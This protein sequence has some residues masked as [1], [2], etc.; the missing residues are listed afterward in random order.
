[1]KKLLFFGVVGIIMLLLSGCGSSQPRVDEL[2]LSDAVVDAPELGVVEPAVVSPVVEPSRVNVQ[3]ETGRTPPAEPERT[4]SYVSNVTVVAPLKTEVNPQL[5]NLLKRA[6]EKVSS[7]QY[8][9]GGTMTSNLFIDTYQVKG[10]SMKVKL[11]EE[12]YYVRAGYYDTIYVDQGIGCCEKLS[13]C[14]SHNVDNTKKKFEVDVGKLSIPKTPYQWAMEVPGDAKIVGPQT[15]N[16]RSVTFVK[17]SKDGIDVE[18]LV[19]DMYG[20]PHKVFLTYPNG[21]VI[22][23]QFNDLK[24]NSLK[25]ADFDAPCD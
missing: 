8:L 16:E 20:V 1:M 23:H 14:E 7:L 4:V 17:Y 22:K 18:M 3:P 12:E 15:F 24:F 19:D 2:P 9:Y 5:R 25:D 13:R 6:D 21:D 10:A 11:Y